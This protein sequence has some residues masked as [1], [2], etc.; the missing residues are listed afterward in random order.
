MKEVAACFLCIMIAPFAISV[1]I[2]WFVLIAIRNAKGI[3]D[4]HFGK[5]MK[6]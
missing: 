1:V 3:D 6:P 2:V 5:R 4:P